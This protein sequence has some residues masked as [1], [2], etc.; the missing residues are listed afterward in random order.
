LLFGFNGRPLGEPLTD[1]VLQ[2]SNCAAADGASAEAAGV[3][4]HLVE[5]FFLS[6]L[7]F[8]VF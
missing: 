2:K 8:R 7:R 3:D 1:I 5:D 6:F 4:F